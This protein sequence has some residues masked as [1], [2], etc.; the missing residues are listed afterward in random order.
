MFQ[1][2]GRAPAGGRTAATLVEIRFVQL[3]M[4]VTRQIVMYFCVVARNKSLVSVHR[5]NSVSERERCVNGTEEAQST[6]EPKT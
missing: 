3:V 2:A 6:A 1:C 4:V 5:K